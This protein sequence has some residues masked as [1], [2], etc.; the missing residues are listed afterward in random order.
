MTAGGGTANALPAE[1]RLGSGALRFHLPRVALGLGLAVLT[2]V[3]FPASPAIDFPIYEVGSVA[4]DNV[5]AP[6]AFRVLKSSAELEAERNAV[7][8][9]VEPVY[10][11][12]PAAL[13][14]ARR[15]L[16]GF[17][18]AVAQ[19]VANNPQ[20]SVTAVQRTA[21]SW[22]ISLSVG[23]AVYLAN[24]RRRTTLV[25]SVARAFDRWLA[26]G[27]A[28]AGALDSVRGAIVLRSGG[29]DHTARSPAPLR[30]RRRCGSAARS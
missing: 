11:F 16:T 30:A 4:S 2:Y 3:L 28:A 7:A 10:D 27:V 14:S 1:R 19:T 29:D 20:A 15:G 13:D 9:G 5:I 18:A 21:L 22:G 8:R 25:Q 17:A 26:A 12:V 23:Q 24:E 6:F